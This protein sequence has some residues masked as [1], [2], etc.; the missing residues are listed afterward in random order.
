MILLFKW[1]SNIRLSRSSQNQTSLDEICEFYRKCQVQHLNAHH[2]NKAATETNFLYTVHVL[3]HLLCALK[4]FF[5][6]SMT[7]YI[8]IR[9]AYEL[10]HDGHV[11]K[12]SKRS[13]KTSGERFLGILAYGGR[14]QS[15]RFFGW[16]AISF[17]FQ[18]NRYEKYDLKKKC[19]TLNNMTQ[20]C[21]QKQK[22]Q[23]Y[24]ILKAGRKQTY[25]T[26]S[27]R[28]IESSLAEKYEMNY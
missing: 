27:S 20:T 21:W 17:K 10:R 19:I 22:T 24:K 5:V 15:H 2:R 7:T 18:R 9:Q 11:F 23:F 13:D 6:S 16:A 4:S 1:E 8:K 28:P 14:R 12:G 25:N 26:R 3:K